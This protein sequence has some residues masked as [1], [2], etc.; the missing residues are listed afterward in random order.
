MTVRTQIKP[1]ACGTYWVWAA[2]TADN[3]ILVC[4][5]CAARAD[6]CAQADIWLAAYEQTG[7]PRE[8][9]RRILAI[10]GARFGERVARAA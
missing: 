8:A 6:A 4:A 7:D 10:R 3:Q 5:S 2:A 9:T 1:S